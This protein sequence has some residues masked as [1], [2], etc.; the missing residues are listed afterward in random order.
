MHEMMNQEVIVVVMPNG[1]L[2]LEWTNTQDAVSK[3]SRLLQEEIYKHFTAD[4]DS[5]LLFLGFC[6]HQVLLSPSLDYWRSFTGDRARL[7]T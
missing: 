2:Q 5:W 4:A 1:L 3:D 7:R 6:D